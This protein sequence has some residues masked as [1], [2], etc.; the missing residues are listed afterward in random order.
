MSLESEIDNG[1][2]LKS[3]ILKPMAGAASSPGAFIE[4]YCGQE[5]L[6]NRMSMSEFRTA[7]YKAAEAAS[8]NAP[9]A[10]FEFIFSD[11]SDYAQVICLPSDN[12][13]CW[14]KLVKTSKVVTSIEKD[15]ILNFIRKML[16]D[17][18]LY[19]RQHNDLPSKLTQRFLAEIVGKSSLKRRFSTKYKDHL[20]TII[21]AL[22][23][24]GELVE[25][26]E[27]E[28][29]TVYKTRAKFYKLVGYSRANDQF[30]FNV[31]AENNAS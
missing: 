15:D 25:I 3:I 11:E 21:D 20:D 23:A 24:S 9:P 26:D 29:K 14:S 8:A 4:F 28:L 18:N 12:G 7:C 19:S 6:A 10:F 31:G 30:N 22:I 27:N 2:L 17:E 13:I 16:D 1:N 5:L